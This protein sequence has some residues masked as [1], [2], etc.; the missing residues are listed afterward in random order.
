MLGIGEITKDEVK[1]NYTF[2]LHELEPKIFSHILPDT[3][4]AS[5]P[6]EDCR[7]DRCR[8]FLEK[9]LE[10]DHC[11]VNVRKFVK[12]LNQLKL[13]HILKVLNSSKRSKNMERA[14]VF[15]NDF[16]SSI[17]TEKILDWSN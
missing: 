15:G 13:Y 16:L 4:Q 12:A 2:L 11:D 10:S 7:T 1:E 17:P 3:E 5:V 14:R 6:T 9:L 8:V